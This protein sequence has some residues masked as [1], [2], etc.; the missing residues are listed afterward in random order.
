MSNKV[1]I[2]G[3]A[4]FI[5][6]HLVRLLLEQD[7]ATDI[8]IIDNLATGRRSNIEPCLNERCRLI[9][10]S[11]GDTLLDDAVLDGVRHIYHLAAGVG[12]KLVVDNPTQMIHNNLHETTTAINA[13]KKSGAALLITSSS[14]VYGKCPVLP[15][16]EDMDVVYG[17]TTASRWSYAMTK[18][19]DE[20]LALDAHRQHGLKAVIVR[21][22]NTVGPRQVGRYGMVI[23]RFVE[24]ALKGQTIEVHGDGEQTR[25]FCDVRDVVQAFPQLIA[26]PD[27]HGQIYNVGSDHRVT[28]NQLAE[29]V[30]DHVK[31]NGG[32]THRSYEAVYGKGFEDPHDRLPDISKL[33]DTIDFEPTIRLRQTI[34]D[35]VREMSCNRANTDTNS[36]SDTTTP[37]SSGEQA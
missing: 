2:T 31:P 3:G 25:T 9:E 28:I 12:V 4:G 1:V 15:L 21:L 5:G 17:P 27:C 18:A 24:R 32:M 30:L 10:A 6:S 33:R 14:E 19:I 11:V 20:H 35:I 22:F 23:P 29:L 7:S 26:N 16:K 36:T 13:A 8:T 37:A 34:E